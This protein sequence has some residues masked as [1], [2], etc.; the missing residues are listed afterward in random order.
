MLVFLSGAEN[1]TL[2]ED[3]LIQE[4]LGIKLERWKDA[5]CGEGYRACDWLDGKLWQVYLASL[6]HKTHT[7]EGSE[8]RNI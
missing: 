8:H 6:H 4:R 7:N 5:S 1:Q 3:A 2:G